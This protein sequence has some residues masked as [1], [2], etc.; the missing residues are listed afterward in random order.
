MKVNLKRKFVAKTG[1]VKSVDF[2][3]TYNWILLGLY[4]GSISI[5]DFNT[6]SSV[7]YVEVSTFPIR[8]AKFLIEKNYIICGAD[9][10]KIRVYNY[11]TMEKITEFEAHKDFIRSIVCHLTLPLFL[12]SSDDNT[13]HLYDASKKFKLVRAYEEHKDFVMKLAINPKDNQMFASASSDKKIKIWS[14]N[15]SNSQLTLEGHLKGVNAV[16]FCPLNDKPYLASGGDDCLVKIWDYTN[17]HCVFTFNHHEQNLSSVCFHPELPILITGSEDQTCKFYNINTGKLEDSKIF[18]YDIIWDINYQKENNIIGF[19]CDEATV[20]CQLGSDEPLATF[21]HIQSKI[22]YCQQNNIYSINLKQVT[23]ETKDGEIISIPPKNLGSSE[24][25]PIKIS[26]SPNGRFFSLLNDSD[27]IISNAGVYRSTVLGR[28][29]DISWCE[30]DTFIVKDGNSVKIYQDLKE[31]RTFKPGF[32]FDNIFG[33]PLFA[34]KTEDAIYLYDI[35]N[36]IFIRKIDVSPEKIIW[37]DKKNLVALI[38]EDV[39][40]LLEV[41]FKAIEGYIEEIVDGGKANEEGCE[42]SF[43]DSYDI[44]EKILNGFFI[45]NVFIYQSEKNKINYTIHQKIFNITTLSKKYYLLGNLSN[46][47][48]LYLI[49][50]DF[51]LI[52]YVFP[53]NFINYQI[54]I[55]DKNYDLAEKLLQ[56]IPE[57]YNEKVIN[58]LEKFNLSDLSYKITKNPNQKFS[59][60]IKLKKLND[61]YQIANE[62]KSSEKL[63]IVADLALELGEFDYAENSMKEANDFNSLLLYY[64]CIQDREKLRNLAENSQK[65][66]NYNVS[67]S[68]YFQIND[69]ENCL[70]ILIDSKRY[71]EASIF[72]RTYIPSKLNEIIELWNGEIEKEDEN[73]RMSVKIVNPV[74]EENKE[75]LEK[76]ENINKNFYDKI[77]EGNMELQ[78]NYKKFYDLDI[79]KSIMDGEDI[80]IDEIMNKE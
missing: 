12:T 70:K 11:N 39:T 21:N 62:S 73:N 34:V 36:L 20:V 1:K 6:N 35:E 79:Y 75:N 2:H 57:E 65:N 51:Q 66:G 74:S 56:N 67:F 69:V 4:N 32:S 55:L 78:N 25:Y 13:I 50:K 77:K 54:A 31:A 41:N 30:N 58:F 26:Y 53:Q 23:H 46:T 71:P 17:K 45:D 14:F 5:Y 72:A 40:Y 38:C 49:N 8:A 16:A 59:L 60:A 44:D 80:N 52:S 27:F 76:C 29:V 42:E 19:G 61:A 68:A 7:Q 15:I 3:L 48:R 63:K 9:D 47:N 37:N 22:I 18:G 28:A 43:G 10:K 64:S 33:G 24:V